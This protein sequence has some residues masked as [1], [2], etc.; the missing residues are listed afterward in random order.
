[1]NKVVVSD[2]SSLVLLQK[3]RLLEKLLKKFEV[4]IPR[5]VYKEAVTKGKNKK[6]SDAYLIEEKI[7]NKLIKVSSVKD[8]D[9]VNQVIKEFGLGEGEAEAI[10]LFLEQKAD[11]LATDD[12]KAI[13]VCKIYEI[14]FITALTFVI[15]AFDNKL[16]GKEEAKRM[17][18]ELGSYGRYKYELVYKALNYVGE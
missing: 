5:E 10:I 4:I 7:K 17:I 9:K 3:I 6:S 2:A 14:P 11:I 12:H 18:K 1:M 13:N 16:I 15:N 8:S